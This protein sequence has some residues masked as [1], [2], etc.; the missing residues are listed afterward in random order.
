MVFFCEHATGVVRYLR[1]IRQLR[2]KASVGCPILAG[3]RTTTDESERWLSDTYRLSDKLLLELS[4]DRHARSLECVELITQ[5]GTRQVI[6]KCH[7]Q[8]RQF[9]DIVDVVCIFH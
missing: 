6:F 4:S 9:C 3:Y 2:M 1:D 8:I 5:Q 7:V